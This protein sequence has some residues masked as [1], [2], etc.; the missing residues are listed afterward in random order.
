VWASYGIVFLEQKMKKLI[1]WDFDGVISDTESIWVNHRM[2]FLNRHYNLN[3]DF[4]TTNKYIGG[5]SERE[6]KA[7]LKN[8]GI[9]IDDNLWKQEVSTQDYQSFQKGL[10]L[11]EDIE[12]IF[13]M[14]CFDQCM[15]TGGMIK[16]TKAKIGSVGI[17]KYFPLSKVFTA[18]L[19][20]YGK[21]EPDLFLLAADTFGYKPEDCIVIEDSVAGLTAAQRAKMTA[22]AF[23]KYN[24]Q[25]CID[26]IKKMN[27]D[28]IADNMKD[29]K[30]WLE[31]FC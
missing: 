4:D 23:I 6:K 28:Y 11:T 10:S 1:I 21:P 18:D 25:S 9:D 2:N 12:Q 8:L 20:A 24:C 3:W 13:Q 5:I 14:N 26:E 29:I 7:V 31:Q 15:A 22:V 30:K 27:V 19:V 17:E 16:D